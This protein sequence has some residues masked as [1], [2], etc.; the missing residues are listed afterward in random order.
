M[1]SQRIPQSHPRTP[2][3]V[4]FALPGIVA[5]ICLIWFAFPASARAAQHPGG[6]TANPTILQ[7][8]IARPAVVRILT[9]YSIEMVTQLCPG[10]TS[11]INDQLAFTG[12]GAFISSQGDILTADHVINAPTD[13]L[14]IGA[15]QIEAQSLHDD[16][17]A[18]CAKV[19]NTSFLTVQQT[20][21]YF[22]EHLDQ[23]NVVA[24]APQSV[25]WLPTD[26]VGSYSQNSIQSIKNYPLTVRA[27]SSYNVNDLAIVRIALPDTP[28]LPL[29]VSADVAPTDTLTMLGFPGS[30]DVSSSPNDLLTESIDPLTVSAL[31]HNSDSGGGSLI[32]VSGNVEHG[33]S[34]GPAINA[35][36]QIVGVVSFS[37]SDFGSTRFLQASESVQ[38]LVAQ[39]NLNLTPGH[40]QTLWQQAMLDYASTAPNH[41]HTATTELQALA[42][43]YPEFNAAQPY[44]N[45]ARQQAATETANGSSGS[46]ASSP[47]SFLAQITPQQ[48]LIVV[49]SILVL[50]LVLLIVVISMGRRRRIRR[51][52]RAAETAIPPMSGYAPSMPAP[53]YAP[54]MPAPGYAPPMPMPG[55]APAM[56][57]P[58]Y[59]PM[60]GPPQPRMPESSSGNTA[61]RP[62]ATGTLSR[63]NPDAMDHSVGVGSEMPR[64]QAWPP[65]APPPF[66]ADGDPWGAAPPSPSASSAPWPPAASPSTPLEGRRGEWLPDSGTP[67][68][69]QPPAALPPSTVCV[70]GH[71]MAPNATYCAICGAP[72]AV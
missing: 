6:N 61:P 43:A 37:L 33:D 40:F 42:T 65:V 69:Q 49:A 26:Y 34:G 32:E 4:F 44:L 17:Q 68:T 57:T 47:T 39:L 64:Y 52:Q 22:S 3:R 5:M 27:E 51:R 10:V 1:I 8:D 15:I 45:Y 25:V 18:K 62:V 59:A 54:S 9:A 19:L 35:Q 12:S 23:V 7:I 41:W 38:P 14:K 11:T 48:L 46:S 28:S 55:Y 31:K 50:L 53:G 13:V 29:G 58:G 16:L 72:R 2:R 71:V 20:I 56:P 30:A 36:G 70:H 63:P 67:S 66:M 24:S 60:Y 21:D